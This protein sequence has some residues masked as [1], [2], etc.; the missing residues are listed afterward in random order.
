MALEF[1]IPI[2]AVNDNFHQPQ[3][4]AD[5]GLEEERELGQTT[6]R[7]KRQLHVR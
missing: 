1:G 3:Q 6:G 2:E 7:F 4:E 5:P